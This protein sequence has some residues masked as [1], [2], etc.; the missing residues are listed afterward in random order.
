MFQILCTHY[1][2][3][4]ESDIFGNVFICNN[5]AP[6]YFAGSIRYYCGSTGRVDPI[7]ISP[8]LG[9]LG[10][11]K[12]EED[13]EVT[14]KAAIKRKELEVERSLSDEQTV[15]RQEQVI[16]EKQIKTE[17]AQINKQFYCELCN[18]QYTKI[19]EYE[20]HLSSYDHH[21]K[22]RFIEMKQI[23]K[24]IH[25]DSRVK[26]EQLRAQK[27]MEKIMQMAAKHSKGQPQP[28]PPQ[29]PPPSQPLPPQPP[30]PSQP[31]P[32]PPPST[33]QD[34]LDQNQPN[35]QPVPPPP[36][37]PPDVPQTI[38]L[39]APIKVSPSQPPS[40]PVK[41]SFFTAKKK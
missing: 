30:P 40:Q 4:G 18:K 35:A 39:S 17:V 1:S 34:N 19:S 3:Y 38:P 32:P 23:D 24:A 10:V 2:F 15:K 16:K 22:K 28:L 6:F 41:F 7:K 21:H 20:T 12:E 33:P 26:K 13:A 8:P 37:T 29:P 11:G 36:A 14:A 25:K 5:S 31:F 27:E 9:R